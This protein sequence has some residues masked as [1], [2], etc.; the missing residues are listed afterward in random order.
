MTGGVTGGTTGGGAGVTGGAA[1]TR[2]L[3]STKPPPPTL[4]VE[5]TLCE[6]PPVLLSEM[7]TTGTPLG[8]V[9]TLGRLPAG[10]FGSAMTC[11]IPG[12]MTVCALIKMSNTRAICFI[13]VD[14]VAKNMDSADG[15]DAL[16]VLTS[17]LPRN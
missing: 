10:A 12:A 6:T 15:L 11:A 9:C 13:A 4:K 14:E 17:V 3:F 2:E 5:N 8:A 7:L 1:T 16:Y